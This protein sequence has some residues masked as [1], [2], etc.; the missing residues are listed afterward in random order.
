MGERKR[1]RSSRTTKKTTASR[2]TGISKKK[3]NKVGYENLFQFVKI[4]FGNNDVAF[5]DVPNYALQKHRFMIN[6]FFAINY[7]D[8]ANLF[9]INKI[10][11]AN[12]VKMWRRVG[13]KYTRVPGWIYTKVRKIESKKTKEY[14]PK[15]IVL[16]LFLE[17]NELSIREYKEGLKYNKVAV[18]EALK[19]FE[20]QL[21][22]YE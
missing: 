9:N 8:T 12:V 22:D 19:V 10:N 13:K 1:K 2:V 3:S 6:R 17:K 18:I 4:I 5:D 21:G 11:G 16:D 7:P 20:K 15:E 14:V